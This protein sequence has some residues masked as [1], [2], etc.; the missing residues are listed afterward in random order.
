LAHPDKVTFEE[1]RP[2]TIGYDKLALVAIEPSAAGYNVRLCEWDIETQ[3]PGRLVQGSVSRSALGAGVFR[4]LIEAFSPLAKVEAVDAKTANLRF[5]AAE[6]PLRSDIQ[7]VRPGD[8]Y[9]P[10]LRTNHRDGH[11][12]AIRPLDWT[13][14]DVVKMEGTQAVCRVHSGLRSALGRRRRGRTE[15]Y[16]LALAPASGPTRLLVRSRTDPDRPLAGYDV[17]AYGPDSKATEHLGRTERDG[18]I[19]VPAGSQPLRLLIVKHGDALL[20]RLPIVPGD[21]PQLTALVPDDDRRLE[22]EGV[23]V[24]LQENLVDLVVRRAI[25]ASQARSRIAAGKID[26]AG[27]FIDELRRLRTQQ[28]FLRQL[29]QERQRLISNDPV[30]Q[31]K[32]DKLFDDTTRLLSNQL[33]PREIEMLETEWVRARDQS[34]K[35]VPPAV[36]DAAAQN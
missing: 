5:R 13:Y 18:G 27:R 36:P 20:A 1:I 19:D 2:L 22:A 26:E 16:A 17:Y 24:G 31:K 29:E 34:G 35:P 6:L 33:L 25:L 8:M 4:L 14:L 30:V 10:I 11:A 9:R 28:Q 3:Q 15:Q 21:V 7:W 12:K 23:I 32:I